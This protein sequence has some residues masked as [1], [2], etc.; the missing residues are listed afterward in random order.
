[1]IPPGDA[2]EK[3]VAADPPSTTP[4]KPATCEKMCDQ[5]SRRT[6]SRDRNDPKSRLTIPSLFCQIRKFF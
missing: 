1:M 2:Q 6:C 4:A 3:S 5:Q